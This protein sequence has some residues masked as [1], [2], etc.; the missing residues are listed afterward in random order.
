MTFLVR[1][2]TLYSVLYRVQHVKRSPRPRQIARYTVVG[3]HPLGYVRSA[4]CR[5]GFTFPKSGRLVTQH[6][7]GFIK[8]LLNAPEARRNAQTGGRANFG[9]G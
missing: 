8:F 1:R 9:V 4:L 6:V 2:P 3:A 5:Y 7:Q